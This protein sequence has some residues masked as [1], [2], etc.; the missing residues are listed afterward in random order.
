LSER[1]G[2]VPSPRFPTTT[3]AFELPGL[4]HAL[5][6]LGELQ[7]DWVGWIENGLDGTFVVVLAPEKISEL[8]ELMASVERWIAEQAFLA[9]RFHLDAR[10]Y[11][12]Q[13]GGYVG[14]V[15]GDRDSDD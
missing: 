1:F 10:V 3:A 13:R 2:S 6:L 12:M 5:E 14:R 9:I 11:I 7:A 4:T 8:N 15:D